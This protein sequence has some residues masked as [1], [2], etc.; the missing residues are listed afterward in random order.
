M[1]N[2]G[3]KLK[4]RILNS[5]DS[6]VCWAAEDIFNILTK[7]DNHGVKN[8]IEISEL[9]IPIKNRNI[10][11]GT[12]II[13]NFCEKRDSDSNIII[14]C[15][16]LLKSEHEKFPSTYLQILSDVVSF[17]EKCN[18]IDVNDSIG[19]YEYRK[20]M[21]YKN[22]AGLKVLNYINK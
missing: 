19:M 7:I 4:Y 17:Y 3:Y 11:I 6:N 14:V 9:S 21:I 13:T 20:T 10:G 8:I 18:F 1:N 22:N 5:S 12:R 15:A 16:G 2:E